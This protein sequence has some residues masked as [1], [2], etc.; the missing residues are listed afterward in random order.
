MESKFYLYSNVYCSEKGSALL[1]LPCQKNVMFLVFFVFFFKKGWLL[2]LYQ[3][4]KVIQM[5]KETDCVSKPA[6]HTSV[7][8]RLFI[9]LN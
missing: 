7:G 9:K 4:V 5:A 3:G 2:S 6:P 1:T 8:D